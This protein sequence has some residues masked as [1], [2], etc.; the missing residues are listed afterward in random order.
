MLRKLHWQNNEVERSGA[1]RS[2]AG[3]NGRLQQSGHSSA[4][5]LFAANAQGIILR[6]KNLIME[7]RMLIECRWEVFA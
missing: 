7:H 1:K 4:V 6:M 3:K 2:K 5:F